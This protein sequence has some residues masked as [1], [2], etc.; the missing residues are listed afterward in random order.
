MNFENLQCC[1]PMTL[2]SRKEDEDT[3]IPRLTCRGFVTGCDA[4]FS[5]VY[6]KGTIIPE[7]KFCPWCGQ[8]IALKSEPKET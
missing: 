5:K 3:C 8:L 7:F 1:G 4:E 6:V 2:F